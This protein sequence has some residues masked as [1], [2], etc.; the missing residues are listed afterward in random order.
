MIRVLLAFVFFLIIFTAVVF[1]VMQAPGIAS[2]TYGGTTYEIPL[3]EFVIGSFILFILFYLMIRLLALIFSAPKRIQ[4]A[5]ESR[6]KFKA[7]DNTQQGLRKFT[8][9]DW[10]QSEKLLLSGADQ[11]DSATTNYIWAARAA[12]MRGDFTERDTNLE[13]ARKASPDDKLELDA[14]SAELLLDQ[15]MP[16]QALASLSQ[17]EA[18]L[19]SN[20]NI[21]VLSAKAHEQLGNWEKMAEMFPHFKNSKNIDLKTARRLE[22]QAI[23]GLINNSQSGNDLDELGTK[24]R[25][26]IAADNDLTLDYVRALRQHNKHELAESTISKA[27]DKNWCSKLVRQYGLINFKD[28]SQAL[29]KA[30]K[31]AE[32]HTN[33]ENLYLTMGRICNKAKLWGKAKTYFESSLSRKPLAETYTELVALHEQLKETEDAQ[34]CAKKG[35]QLATRIA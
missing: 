13:R 25:D 32:Q 8:Q 21:A 24:Y 1:A 10:L 26:R 12:H 4:A 7:L 22:H 2:I 33:D 31:W 9:G 16:E 19:R 28:P 3:V 35:L 27:L 15:G 6:R 23:K 20:P 17:H 11:T 14:L 34:R 30:E 18:M 5:R 29:H